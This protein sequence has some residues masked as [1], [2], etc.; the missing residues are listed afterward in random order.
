M[1]NTI[2]DHCSD[3]VE[4]QLQERF[5][6]LNDRWLT[7]SDIIVNLEVSVYQVIQWWAAYE[8][9]YNEVETFIADVSSQITDEP[10][11]SS[12]KDFSLLPKYKVNI[13]AVYMYPEPKVMVRLFPTIFGQCLNIL[14]K[15]LLSMSNHV[16][17]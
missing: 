15:V 17:T 4:E 10:L 13:T 2:L 7:V 1:D 14:R 6:Q 8:K 5:E 12:D 11:E 3:N 16:T 9:R